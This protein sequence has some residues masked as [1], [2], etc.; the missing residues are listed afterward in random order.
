MGTDLTTTAMKYQSEEW[1]KSASKS[2]RR[3]G[4]QK[5]YN[6]QKQKGIKLDGR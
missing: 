1:L 3:G 6:S 5:T 4:V 2:D